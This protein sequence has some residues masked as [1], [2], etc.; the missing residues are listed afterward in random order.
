M[1]WE[2]TDSD[3]DLTAN[4]LGG[5]GPIRKSTWESELMPYDTQARPT[6]KQSTITTVGASA[7]RKS[8]TGDTPFGK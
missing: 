1:K 2:V 8:F 3:Q 4:I 6:R 7:A 5:P